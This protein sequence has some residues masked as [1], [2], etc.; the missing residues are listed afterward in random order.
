M[1]DRADPHQLP[2]PLA[3]S[4]VHRRVREPADVYDAVCALRQAGWR[5]YR[6][7]TGHKTITGHGRTRLLTNSQLLRAAHQFRK[8]TRA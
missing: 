3:R 4:V 5:V 7:A 1:K 2:L 8:E 6:T